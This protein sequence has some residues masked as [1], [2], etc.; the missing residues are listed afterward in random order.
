M[1]PTP[2][3][4]GFVIAPSNGSWAA[5]AQPVQDA[6]ASERIEIIWIADVDAQVVNRH[7]YIDAA[8]FVIAD[9]T[10]ENPNVMYEIGY[11]YGHRKPVLPIIERGQTSVPS[12][13]K[14]RLF[15][16]Y[17]KD[18]P[19]KLVEFL[20]KWL[21]SYLAHTLVEEAVG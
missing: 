8:D 1:E 9:V 12:S 20:K 16:V 15:F 3:S 5:I 18:D 21:A 14:G 10:G 11:A 17:D 6:L 13:L 7:R 2:R 4:T 19:M